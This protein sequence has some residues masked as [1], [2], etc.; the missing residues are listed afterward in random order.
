[1]TLAEKKHLK[2]RFWAVIITFFVLLAFGLYLATDSSPVYDELGRQRIRRSCLGPPPFLLLAFYGLPIVLL[3]LIL[4][5][6][7]LAIAKK[8]N[9]KKTLINILLIVGFYGAVVL[10]F[11]L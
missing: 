3:G 10:L 11:L 2:T 9:A 8:L 5:L 4:D 6:I 1:M 7:F